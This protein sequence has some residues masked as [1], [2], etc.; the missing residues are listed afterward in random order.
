[1]NAPIGFTFAKALRSVLRHDPEIVL[2]G[3][4]RDLETAEIAIR[5]SLTGHMLF[6]TLHTNDAPSAATRLIDM[7]V[8]G[9]M[10]MST[11]I[12]VL[13]Q[14]LVR[15]LCPTCKAPLEVEESH[16]AA[17]DISGLP[18]GATPY[19]AI[20]CSEC[21][22]TGYKGRIAIY[23]LLEITPEMRRLKEAEMTAEVLREMAQKNDFVSLRDSALVRWY[24][25]VTSLDEVIKITIE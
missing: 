23:E 18:A 16:L 25:G 1:M 12:G 5:A 11:L 19:K 14:R 13:A 15:R 21:N 22:G 17:V 8:P 7:G 10:V 6:S 9:F 4:I 2:L 3:E 20:G 24:D